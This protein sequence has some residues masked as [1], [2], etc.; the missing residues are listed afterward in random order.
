MRRESS[1]ESRVTS[2]RAPRARGVTLV[3]M[4]VVIAITGIVAAAI[5]I[6]VRSPVEGYVDAARRA[7]LT[8]IAD[9]ALRRI[10]RDLR[11][12][13]PNSIR[14]T[15]SGN[16]RYIEYLQTKGGGRYRADKDSGG[17]GFPLDVTAAISDFDV[18]GT[19]PAL[20]SGDSIVI[21]NLTADSAVPTGNAYAGD[22]REAYSSNTAT[23]IT[24]GAAKQFPFASPGKRFQVVQYPVTYSCDPLP[25]GTGQL[26]RYWGYSIAAVQPTPPA[27]GSNALLATNVSDCSFSYDPA[28]GASGRTGVVALILQI[29]QSGEKVRLFQQV[30]V[31]NVP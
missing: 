12:A 27:G 13:L 1:H 9:T 14:T 16:V 23:T 22:N 26:R 17:A 28:T 30:H 21:Y 15:T 3:E 8:D 2:H 6:F 24:L 4:I 19:M 18:I 29:E 20:A 31:S 25:L 5:A 10:T 11:T 7:E